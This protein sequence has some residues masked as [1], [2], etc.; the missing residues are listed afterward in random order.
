MGTAVYGVPVPFFC[1]WAKSK[2]R[3]ITTDEGAVAVS[4]AVYTR[5]ELAVGDKVAAYPT[6]ELQEEAVAQQ[7]PPPAAAVELVDV[8]PDETT[9]GKPFYAAMG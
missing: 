3:E 5:S 9:S 7:T 1:R 4:V 2:K 8:A 6:V